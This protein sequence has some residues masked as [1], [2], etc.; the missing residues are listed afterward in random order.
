MT[1][2]HI[3]K[4]IKSQQCESLFWECGNSFPNKIKLKDHTSIY[5][6]NENVNCPVYLEFLTKYGQLK[7]LYTSMKAIM[8]ATDVKKDFQTNW[9]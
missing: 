3:W 7:R 6:G 5:H 4:D 9:D 1:L 2:K 8:F